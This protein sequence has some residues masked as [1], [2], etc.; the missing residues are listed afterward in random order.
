MIRMEAAIGLAAPWVATM[1]EALLNKPVEV[2]V[3]MVC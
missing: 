1:T 3:K 2:S